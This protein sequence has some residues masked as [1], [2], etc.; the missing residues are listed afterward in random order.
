[1]SLVISAILGR[2]LLPRNEFNDS[3]IILCNTSIDFSIDSN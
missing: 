2:V 1:M 3:V